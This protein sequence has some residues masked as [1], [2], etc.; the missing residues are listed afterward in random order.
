MLDRSKCNPYEPPKTKSPGVLSLL[1]LNKL[2]LCRIWIPAKEVQFSCNALARMNQKSHTLF[3]TNLSSF[4]KPFKYF[5]ILG[6]TYISR[7]SRQEVQGLGPSE[8]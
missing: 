5:N 7:W 4:Y 2:L 6:R 8:R 3:L 1:S